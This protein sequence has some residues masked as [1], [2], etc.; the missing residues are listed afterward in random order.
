MDYDE[1]WAKIKRSLLDS[2]KWFLDDDAVRLVWVTLLLM[3]DKDGFVAA[4]ALGIAHRAR[5][6]RD[7][8]DQALEI[9]MSPD[10]D[11][12][13]ENDEGRSL[14]K[15]ARGYLLI[16]YTD[17]RNGGADYQERERQ[18]KRLAAQKRR[19]EERA[20]LD[21]AEPETPPLAPPEPVTRPDG[22]KLDVACFKCGATENVRPRTLGTNNASQLCCEGCYF[23]ICDEHVTKAA[24]GPVADD[25]WQGSEAITSCPLDLVQRAKDV[26]VFKHMAERLKVHESS[27]EDKAREFVTYWTIGGGMGRTKKLWMRALRE[28]IR[29]AAE[30]GK[31]KAPGEIAH[32]ALKTNGS[33]PKKDKLQLDRERE[34]AE[35]WAEEQKLKAKWLRDNGIPDDRFADTKWG[36]H[37]RDEARAKS[38]REKEALENERKKHRSE[39]ASKERPDR[40]GVERVRGAPEAMGNGARSAHAHAHLRK[41]ESEVDGDSEEGPR[42]LEGG[43]AVEATTRAVVKRPRNDR[44]ARDR[45]LLQVDQEAIAEAQARNLAALAEFEKLLQ[46]EAAEKSRNAEAA[47]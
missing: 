21:D 28:D 8:V 26:G 18:R 46:L 5:V 14:R 11:S 34:Q 37:C 17:H 47:E 6:P 16:N 43:R 3:A 33:G 12:R 1:P 32:A 4:N 36:N 40:R 15:V 27:I 44:V 9:F 20:E 42:V 25:P 38:A 35:E 22:K 2:S 45:P 13:S 31:L 23:A 24:T 10:P 39:M 19:A 29:R 7:K 41:G 30:Q